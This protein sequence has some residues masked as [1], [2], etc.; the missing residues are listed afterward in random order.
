MGAVFST[1]KSPLHLAQTVLTLGV[2][3]S[4][5]AFQPVGSLTTLLNLLLTRYS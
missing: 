4:A 1:V 3:A 2:A 5:S